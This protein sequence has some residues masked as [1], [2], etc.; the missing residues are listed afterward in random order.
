MDHGDMLLCSVGLAELSGSVAVYGGFLRCSGGEDST[1]RV[2]YG[3]EVITTGGF[4][5]SFTY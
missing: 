4:L 1:V 2:G 3:L 5:S